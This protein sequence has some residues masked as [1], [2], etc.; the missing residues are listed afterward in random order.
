MIWGQPVSCMVKLSHLQHPFSVQGDTFTGEQ[1][2]MWTPL[3]VTVRPLTGDQIESM[4]HTSL[5]WAQI[6]Q[7]CPGAQSVES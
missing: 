4:Q 3:G 2:R 7:L 1:I 5:R 6:L